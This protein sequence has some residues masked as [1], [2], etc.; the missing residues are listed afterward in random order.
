MV[1]GVGRGQA[2]VG[3][4][5]S[6]RPP[7]VRPPPPGRRVDFLEAGKSRILGPGNPEIWDPKKKISKS[8][9]ILPKMLA[10]PGLVGKNPPGPIWGHPG[11]FSPWTEKS[12]NKKT[13]KKCL[14]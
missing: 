3:S 8:K 6:V 7:S 11:P 14:C 10:R 4:P 12:K 1:R 5:P 9:S 13:N 2:G